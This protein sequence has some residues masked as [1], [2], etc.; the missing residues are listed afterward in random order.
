MSSHLHRQIDHLKGA[1]L[2][3]GAVVEENVRR[4]VKALT[5]RD[6]ELAQEVMRVDDEQV[7]RSEVDIEE[8]CLKLLALYQ[9]VAADLRFIVAVLKINRDLERIGDMAVNI[10]ERAAFLAN[11]PPLDLPL[12]F[13]FH[14]MADRTQAMLKT[15]LDSLVSLDVDLAWQ[16]RAADDEVDELNSQMYSHV[17]ERLRTHPAE[18]EHLLHLLAVA[19]HLERIADHATNIAKDVIYMVEGEIVRHKARDY[20]SQF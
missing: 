1:A 9:P 13:D 16:V 2:A 11:E 7:D 18:V 17:Q 12:D 10:A 3:L 15:S 20:T 6:Q 14:Q 4:A 19:R 5:Q 8:E